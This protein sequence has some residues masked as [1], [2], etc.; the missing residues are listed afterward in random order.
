MKNLDIPASIEAI[1]LEEYRTGYEAGKKADLL[2]AI[3]FCL[4]QEII[5]PDWIVRAFAAATNRW[6]S[7]RAKTLDDAF[8]IKYPKGA[9][10]NASRKRR[11]LTP[12]VLVAVGNARA[13]GRPVDDDLFEEIG[14]SLRPPIGKTLVKEYYAATKNS[15]R[16]GRQSLRRQK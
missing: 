16:S 12:A 11:A 8:G 7:L 1:A 9:H 10:L 6:F 5:P 4:D 13:E 3:R 14:K 2:R 15:R